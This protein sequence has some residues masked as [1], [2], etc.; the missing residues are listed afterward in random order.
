VWQDISISFVRDK[1]LAIAQSTKK[2][3]KPRMKGSG[4]TLENQ[5]NTTGNSQI[6]IR[7]PTN[8]VHIPIRIL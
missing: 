7:N 6:A 8:M 1:I 2:S 4:N 5:K 3:R